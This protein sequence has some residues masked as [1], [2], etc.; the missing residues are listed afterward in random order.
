MIFKLKTHYVG[1]LKYKIM[2]FKIEILGD[3]SKLHPKLKI[4]WSFIKRLKLVL[5]RRNYTLI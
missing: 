2:S 3:S 4:K 1:I 5:L